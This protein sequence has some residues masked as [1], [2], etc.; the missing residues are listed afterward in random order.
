[1]SGILDGLL[2]LSRAE[3]IEHAHAK[4]VNLADLARQRLDYFST[5]ARAGQ[6]TMQHEIEPDAFVLA[7]P[8]HVDTMLA[9]LIDNAIKYTPPGGAV[10]LSIRVDAEEI[11]LTLS[12]SGIGF[13]P[14]ERAHLFDRF[15][16]SDK[17]TVRQTHGSGLGLSIV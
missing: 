6:I 3:A 15:Y 5:H 4:T 10:C 12:D 7:D 1:M 17:P 9:N 14:A 11:V 8:G 13:E 2:R 16:R